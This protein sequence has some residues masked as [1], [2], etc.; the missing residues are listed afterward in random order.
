M[1]EMIAA[2]LGARVAASSPADP[3]RSTAR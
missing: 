3:E 1:N 2:M